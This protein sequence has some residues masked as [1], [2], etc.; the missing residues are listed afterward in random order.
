MLARILRLG[1]RK[2][3][4]PYR[5]AVLSEFAGPLG[6]DFLK[7]VVIRL[8]LNQWGH[9]VIGEVKK[10]LRREEEAQE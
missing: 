7:K 5:V 9:L 1:A 10:V 6:I 2:G 4:L 8:R 3:Y